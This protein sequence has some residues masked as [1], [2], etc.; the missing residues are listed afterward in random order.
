M[1]KNKKVDNNIWAVR[2]AG[3]NDFKNILYVEIIHK[4]LSY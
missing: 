2:G 4:L 3:P 1:L